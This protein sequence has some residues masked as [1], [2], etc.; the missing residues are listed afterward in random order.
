MKRR[1]QLI[2]FLL[3]VG[4]YVGCAP[5]EFNK[6]NNCGANCVS[7][8]GKKEYRYAVTPNSGK[9][10]ILF[11][12]DNSG[13]MSF[14][15]NAIANRFSTFIAT[16][17]SK[18]IDYRIG[19]ITTDV[20]GGSNP[21][22]AINRNGALQDGRLIEFSNSFP[23]HSGTGLYYI[24]P[25]TA[26]KTA[27]FANTIRRPE[28]L[29][30]EAFLANNP[31][32]GQTSSAYQANCP[33]PDE[34]GIYAANM[35]VQNNPNGFIRSDAHLAIVF[36]G[37][38]DER[39]S[40][41]HQ[42]AS[43]ALAVADLPQALINKVEATYPGKSLKMHS[44]IVRPGALTVSPQE[45]SNRFAM[46][47]AGGGVNASYAP[48]TFFSGGDAGCLNIQSNQTNGVLGSYGY[49]YAL[50]TRLTGGVEGDICASDYGSQLANIGDNIGESFAQRT[51]YCANPGQIDLQTP[52]VT[53][54]PANNGNAYSISG[55]IIHFNP[56]L[57]PGTQAYLQYTCPE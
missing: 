4:Y 22:R 16:L 50:A 39:S 54:T 7:V 42:T 23:S 30:C 13:S 49:L 10:D 55:N 24:T 12:D 41:Y 1:A 11:V 37:D 9:V 28:T 45:A 36:I 38:E 8:N 18:N 14:E 57:A 44:I 26:N 6:D 34:S 17:D 52:M 33:S 53:F 46:I 29:T 2:M 51:L 43:Y 27:L 40:L 48:Q 20:S 15:Q 31:S 5:V 19:I 3:A 32:A 47:N 25:A 56:N 35:T 21:A